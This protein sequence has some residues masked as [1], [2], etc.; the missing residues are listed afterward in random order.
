[1]RPEAK[2]E[3]DKT[4]SIRV[5]YEEDELRL[6]R[7]QDDKERDISDIFGTF[8]PQLCDRREKETETDKD[9]VLKR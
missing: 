4:T 8:S 5:C 3:L 6:S 7:K 2:G 1:M 9:K